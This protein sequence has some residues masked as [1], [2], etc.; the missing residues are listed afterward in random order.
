[1]CRQDDLPRYAMRQTVT[2]DGS[3]AIQFVDRA[4]LDEK[5]AGKHRGGAENRLR[6]DSRAIWIDAGRNPRE[7]DDAW[8]YWL[9]TGASP[10]DFAAACQDKRAVMPGT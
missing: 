6:E 2:Q 9:Q 3:P 1:M 7:F 8:A 10:K 5:A 4:F